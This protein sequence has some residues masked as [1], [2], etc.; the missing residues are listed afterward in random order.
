MKKVWLIILA[1]LMLTGCASAETFETIGDD[2]DAVQVLSPEKLDFAV[3]PDA[4]APVIHSDH[5]TLYFCDGYEIMIQTMAGGDLDRSLRQV[6][7]FDSNSMMVI[8]TQTGDHTRHE[9]V[10]LTAGEG[11]DHV[12][13]TVIIDDGACHYSLSVMASAEEAG[14]LQESWQELF[15]SIK[16]QS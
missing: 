13:R 4:A 15:C 3:P 12:G 8:T 14:S 16:I 7:G 11:G 2:Y 6:T 1:A 10:W 9:C 5:G